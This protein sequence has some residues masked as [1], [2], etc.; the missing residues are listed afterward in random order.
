MQTRKHKAG[1]IVVLPRRTM[2]H[3][4]Q[5][6]PERIHGDVSLSAADHFAWVIAAFRS[7]NVRRLHTLAIDNGNG[8][9]RLLAYRLAAAFA[10]SV[11]NSLPRAIMYPE[12]NDSVDGF[13]FGKV[14]RKRP[15]LTSIS[16]DIPDGIDHLASIHWRTSATATSSHKILDNLSLLVRKIVGIILPWIFCGSIIDCDASQPGRIHTFVLNS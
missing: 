13:P 3:D 5:K 16:I 14:M 10:K 8:R 7:S 11:M 4:R 1:T 12:P 6:Q 15:S 2:H 9:R